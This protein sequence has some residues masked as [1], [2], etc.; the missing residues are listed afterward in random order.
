[1]LYDFS[2]HQHYNASDSVA[3]MPRVNIT[4]VYDI[5]HYTKHVDIGP[6]GYWTNP[7]CD[8]CEKQPKDLLGH[9]NPDPIIIFIT[10]GVILDYNFNI[11]RRDHEE[12]ITRIPSDKKIRVVGF[13]SG[14]VI[15]VLA[16]NFEYT[17]NLDITSCI[18]S[19][20]S[21]SHN[22]EFTHNDKYI[23]RTPKH[24]C[25]FPAEVLKD[26]FIKYQMIRDYLPLDIHGITIRM[27]FELIR[28]DPDYYVVKKFGRAEL[29]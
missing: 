11:I 2:R 26:Q 23:I 22:Y 6:H 27:L 17:L 15:R 18:Q 7:A 4:P 3:M 8:E 10:P 5:D 28:V 13:H 16:G 29:G 14:S 25:D 12:T 1:M 19:C 24:L 9:R 21:C 20:C